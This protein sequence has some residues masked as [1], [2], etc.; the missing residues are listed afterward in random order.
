MLGCQKL[1]KSHD[2]QVTVA[3]HGIFCICL[4]IAPNNMVLSYAQDIFMVLC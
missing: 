4:F 3:F 2:S 1:A